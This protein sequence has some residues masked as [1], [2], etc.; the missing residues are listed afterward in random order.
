VFETLTKADHCMAL[1]LG[2][3]TGGTYTDAVI[4]RDETEVIATA[5]SLTT[6]HDLAEG[7]GSAIRAV[8]EAADIGPNDISLAALSTTLATNA[9]VENQ[10]ERVA[11][12]Y[13]GFTDAD[14]DRSGLRE[15]LKGD[16][17][18]IMNGGHNHDGSESTPLDLAALQGFLGSHRTLVT[19]FAI[20]ACFATRNSAHERQAAAMV[21]DMTGLPV[22]CSHQLSAKLNGPK[23]AL[24]ALLNARLIGTID[25]LIA[26]AHT[27]LEDLGINAPLMVVRGDGALMSAQAAR[28]H[29]IETILSGPAASLVGARW[30]TGVDTALVSDIG[31]TTTDVALLRNGRPAIDPSGAHV[32]AFQTMVEAVAMKTTGLGGDSQVHVM[33]EGLQ[34]GLNLGPKRVV[35]VSLM[36]TYDPESILRELDLQTRSEAPSEHDGRFVR[37]V[38]GAM[39]PTG[40][41]DREAALMDRIAD[42]VQPVG[43]IVRTRIDHRS[44]TQLINRG[45]VQVS[46]V[47]PSDAAH[48]LGLLD[49]WHTEAARLALMSLARRRQGNGQRLAQNPTDMAQFIVDRLTAQTMSSLVEAAFQEDTNAFDAPPEALAKHE[50]FHAGLNQHRGLVALSAHLNVGVVGLGASAPT[51]YPAVGERLGCK[52]LLPEHAG[53]AN[54]IG[55]VVGRVTLRKSGTVTSPSD[56]CYVAHLIQGPIAFSEPEEALRALEAELRQTVVDQ[57]QNS[58]AVDIQTTVSRDVQTAQI[59]SRS[60]FVQATLTAEATGRPQ[61]TRQP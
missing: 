16:P 39:Q 19:G 44:L 49:T 46:G 56:G 40:L 20:A 48:V 10:G 8:I 32:G 3:D 50:L 52:M 14:L 28:A 13:I 35:P 7:I 61:I 34:G 27:V 12:I 6:R 15:A 4:V 1:N 60:M 47:T 21:S 26:K 38:G 29:P 33:T 54:A 17:C 5:K 2:V 30:L 59:E 36:A 9:L 23:R 25:R 45:F 11:L 53:V 24:T 22:S 37:A 42:T 55:A 41:S 43:Q 18:L 51:Y 31:G 57:A 58:G